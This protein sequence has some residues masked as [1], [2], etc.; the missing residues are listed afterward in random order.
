MLALTVSAHNTCEPRCLQRNGN[1]M[2]ALTSSRERGRP[3]DELPIAPS[4]RQSPRMLSTKSSTSTPMSPVRSSTTS[5]ASTPMSPVRSSTDPV[6]SLV[7]SPSS[8]PTSPTLVSVP[9]PM[10]VPLPT[11]ALLPLPVSL[12]L[13]TSLPEPTGA[14]TTTSL[15]EPI[16]ALTSLPD[17]VALSLPVRIGP[18]A[19]SPMLPASLMLPTSLGCHPESLADRIGSDARRAPGRARLPAP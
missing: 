15:P 11:S 14:S 19:M 9:L 2:F 6:R 18:P 12:P 16:G 7:T 17:R 5:L 8:A 1:G 10:S 3:G 4:R 13:P